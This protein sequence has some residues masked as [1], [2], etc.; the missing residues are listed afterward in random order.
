MRLDMDLDDRVAGGA[1][2]QA[3][4]SLTLQPKLLLILRTR[5]KSPR[6]C[7]CRSKDTIRRLVPSAA[8]VNGTVTDRLYRCRAA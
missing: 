6:R 5:R 2:A 1:T 4:N 3:S 8:S 7:S